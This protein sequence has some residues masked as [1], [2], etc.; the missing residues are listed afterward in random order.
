MEGRHL[1][2]IFMELVERRVKK[3]ATSVVRDV[4][5]RLSREYDKSVFPRSCKCQLADE[6]RCGGVYVLELEVNLG[7]EKRD[8]NKICY[9][10]FESEERLSKF[11]SH[12]ASQVK[13][14]IKRQYRT[15]LS[16]IKLSVPG[17]GDDDEADLSPSVGVMFVCSTLKE[18]F[19]RKSLQSYKES[20]DDSVDG[21]VVKRARSV[22]L[23]I[24]I[25]AAEAE[26]A[27]AKV[28]AMRSGV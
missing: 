11:K 20:Y 18:M 13:S 23:G 10:L 12:F 17:F 6:Q 7:S 25:E 14:A 4:S 1:A 16:G 21:P 27:A 5:Q 8:N 26:A 3:Y 24:P 9:E 2:T 15:T 28:A 19:E 22:K